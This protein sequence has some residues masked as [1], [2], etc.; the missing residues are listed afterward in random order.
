MAA[1]G[2]L[3]LPLAAGAAIWLALGS[4]SDLA[5]LAIAAGPVA[6]AVALVRPDLGAAALAGL[7]MASSGLLLGEEYG[8]PNIERV[9]IVVLVAA[10]AL[11]PALRE[12]VRWR[13]PVTVGFTAFAG[14]RL[15]TG[16]VAPHG[17]LYGTVKILAFGALTIGVLILAG[18]RSERALGRILL[19]VVATAATISTFT[20]LKTLGIGGTWGGFAADVIATPEQQQAALRSLEAVGTGAA[21]AAGPIGDPNF[22]A[23]ALVLAFPLAVWLIRDGW[24][25]AVR[26]TGLLSGVMI[27]VGILAAQSRGGLVAATAALTAWGIVEG[28]HFRRVM[29]LVPLVAALVVVGTGSG[30]DRFRD[31][32]DVT[33]PAE[34][35]DDS[36]RGRASEALVAVE[37][38]KDHPL[39]GIGPGGYKPNYGAY[40]PRIGLD[41]R[42]VRE[43]HNSYLEMAA[44][45]GLLGAL[46]FIGMVAAGIASAVVAG[47]RLLAIGDTAGGRLNIAIGAGLLGYAIAAIFLHQAFPQYLW[48][49]LGLSAAG[50]EIAR[51]RTTAAALAPQR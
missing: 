31:L 29:L 5:A 22:W 6:L 21:R 18:A 10:F 9:T 3:A 41:D 40:A 38:F 30:L 13:S 2:V 12:G 7:I 35:R 1:A 51:R 15:L 28:G 37:M 20:A 17:D 49:G 44:E 24:S 16:L 23:Q 25:R 33:H 45:S 43:P 14:A 47:R 36:I 8:V 39:S 26:V 42:Q 4:G 11:R 27:V 19:V 48:L 34:A 50:Y 32:A 46:A